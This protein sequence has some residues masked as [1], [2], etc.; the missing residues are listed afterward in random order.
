MIVFAASDKIQAFK[1]KL[2]FWKIHIG[3]YMPNSFPFV[4][5]FSEEIS[6]N[7]DNYASVFLLL[8]FIITCQHL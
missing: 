8:I 2:V 5:N 4:K 7:N 6:E 1:Q 3:Y